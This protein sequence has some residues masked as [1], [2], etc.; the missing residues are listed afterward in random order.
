MALGERMEIVSRAVYVG[1]NV[2]AKVPLIRLTVDL[3]HRAGKTA[4]DYA[5]LV[6]DPLL[7]LLPGLATARTDAGGSLMG[8]MRDGG[9]VALAELIGHVA[10]ALQLQAGAYADRVLTRPAEALAAIA[11]APTALHAVDTLASA[12]DIDRDQAWAVLGLRL[13]RATREDVERLQLERDGLAAIVSEL[14][15]R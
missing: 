12:F 14:R 3:R 6:A 2:Y 7:K 4:A 5:D 9:P 8:D 15:R 10:L 13:R 11:A 1:P